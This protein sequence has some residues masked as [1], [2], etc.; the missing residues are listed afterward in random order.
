MAKTVAES[1]VEALKN[2]GVKQ[3]YGLPGDSLNGFTDALRKD[4]TIAWAHVRNEEAAAFAAGAEAHLT[5]SL[6]VCAAS[7][8][9][10]NLHL[11]NGLFD[12]HRSRVPV[13]AIAAHI[14]SSEIGTN[15]FQE[16]HPQNLFKECSDY[17]EMIGVP[18]QMPR[19]LEIAMRSAINLSS[20][21]V[22]VIPGEVFAKDVSTSHTAPPIRMARP[23]VRPNDAELREA[24]EILNAGRK[25]TILGG[26]GCKGAHQELLAI[27]EA[28]KSPIVHALRGKEY[29]EYNNPFDV[30]MTGLIGFSSGYHAMENCDV[31]L[32][33]GTDFPYQQ[34]L[35]AH[36]KVI[37]IDIRGNQIGRRTKVDLGLVGSIKETLPALLPLLTSKTERSHLDDKVKDY[38]KVREGLEE[39]AGADKNQ[40]PIHPQ[41]VA[42]LIDKL[43]TDDAIFTCDVGTPTV[44]AARYLSMNGKRRL[45]GSFNHGSMACAVPQAIGAQASHPQRQVITLSGDGGLA[46]M[47]G[48]LLTLRQLNLPIKIVVFNNGSL[49]FVELE[50]K[51]AGIVNYGTELNNP[52][53]ADLARAIG[54]HAARVEYPNDLEAAL[55]TALATPG[56]A[57]VEVIV[58]RQELSMPPNITFAQAKGFSLWAA[59]SILSGRGDEIID[60]AKTNVI[61]RLLS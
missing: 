54:L 44:W 48:D 25:I 58:N 17:C 24:A 40:T 22:L 10:G 15:Y 16:T 27:A 11:I 61:Q 33:L 13:L 30:G 20:V 56:P 18:E 46:M 53:F 35:P 7:C 29:I 36:A 23:V 6:A 31:L 57:L 50:M 26:A 51:A 37:Q 59:K 12:C 4:G 45:L 39:L 21:S 41:Y 34:F 28:L 5:G 55:Q 19:T 3:V 14:P 1:I 42:R 9:P 43:A 49:A 32:M 60:L 47:L 52:N 2:A 38:K 8:G